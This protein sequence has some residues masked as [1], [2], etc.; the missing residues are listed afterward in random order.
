MTILAILTKDRYFIIF[1]ASMILLSFLIFT[2]CSRKQNQT[3]SGNAPLKESIDIAKITP[4]FET[5]VQKAMKEWHVPGAAIG[6]IQGDKLI[7]SKGFG[8]KE[9]GNKDPIDNRTIF[10]IGSLTKAF[11]AT[12]LAFFVDK[13]LVGWYDEIVK[14]DRS[15]MLYGPWVTRNFEIIDLFA[16]HSGLSSY[17]LSDL[18]ELGFEP[19]YML[20]ILRN[21][22]PDSS[23]RSLF[24]YQNALQLELAP[25]SQLLMNK[26]WDVIVKENIIDPLEMN[27]TYFKLADYYRD[28]NRSSCHIPLDSQV[29]MIPLV[30]FIDATGPSGCMISCVQ[31]MAKWISMQLANG[32]FQGK[33]IISEN[34]LKVTRTPQTVIDASIFYGLGWIISHQNPYTLIWHNGDIQGAHN[35]VAFVPEANIGIVVLSNL[36]Q[37]KMPESVAFR[38]LDLAFKRPEKDYSAQYLEKFKTEIQ[39]KAIVH[40]PKNPSPALPNESYIGKYSNDIYGILEVAVKKDKLSLVL[41]PDKASAILHHWNRDVFLVEWEGF[42]QTIGFDEGGKIIF[43]EDP[44]GKIGS[45]RY[46]PSEPIQGPFGFERVVTKTPVVQEPK[47]E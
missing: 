14:Y 25:L 15:F 7:Y 19:S 9:I 47:K 3:T 23:F 2:S 31:D 38:F 4:D 22:K 45:F 18:F 44:E 11:G 32:K 29:Q 6:I 5:Y 8:S 35:V 34:N 37:T 28:E 13:G 36:S 12:L 40:A 43:D 21:V 10:P 39:S 41:Q 20:K 1:Y 26:T 27:H 17:A 30:P 46:F 33:Q 24:G 16:Q 42:L